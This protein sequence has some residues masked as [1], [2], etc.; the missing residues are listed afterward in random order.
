MPQEMSEGA[1]RVERSE[2]SESGGMRLIL[3]PN[4]STV[5]RAGS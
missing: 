4:P 3:I 1:E 2:R 5:L